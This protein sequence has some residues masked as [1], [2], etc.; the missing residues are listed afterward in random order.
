MA[1]CH[2]TAGKKQVNNLKVEKFLLILR[3]IC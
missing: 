1:Y 3:C 2:A